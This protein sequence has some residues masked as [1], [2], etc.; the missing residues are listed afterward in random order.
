MKKLVF[1]V[2]IIL[3][4]SL[5]GCGSSKNKNEAEQN[6]NDATSTETVS[7]KNNETETNVYQDYIESVSPI[8]EEISNFGVQWDELRQQSADGT[9]SD[10]DFGLKVFNELIPKNI[11]ITEQLESLDVDNELVDIHER[12]IDMLNKQNSALSEIASAIDTSDFSKITTANE[13]LSEARKIEREVIREL[14]QHIE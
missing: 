10:Q 5:A 3:T 13:Y 14:E 2:A 4:L 9:L 12:L 11:E 1:S 6:T 8:M 7:T